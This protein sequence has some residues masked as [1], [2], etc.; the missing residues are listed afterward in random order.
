MSKNTLQQMTLEYFNH[1]DRLNKNDLNNYIVG[2]VHSSIINQCNWFLSRPINQFH[3]ERA[4]NNH[5]GATGCNNHFVDSYTGFESGNCYCWYQLS[6]QVIE[7]LLLNRKKK[8]IQLPSLLLPHSEQI[9][10][11]HEIAEKLELF[12]FLG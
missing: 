10:T 12:K 1:L 4:I 2:L 5:A 11:V 3:L 8:A 9:M 6:L 7:L